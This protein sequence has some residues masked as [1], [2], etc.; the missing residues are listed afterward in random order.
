MPGR[1]DRAA[2]PPPPGGYSLVFLR[3]NAADGWEQLCKQ[4]PGPMRAAYNQLSTKPSDPTNADRQHR[5]KFDLEYVKVNGALLEQWQ[6]E[7][8]GGA[9][10]WYAV[11]SMKMLVWISHAG[12]GHPSKSDK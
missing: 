3:K 11:N 8:T 12:T 6:Y 10:I 4:A 7:V 9:R 1:N 5:L 2:P